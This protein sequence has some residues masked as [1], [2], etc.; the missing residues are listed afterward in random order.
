MLYSGAAFFITTLKA[1]SNIYVTC[2]PKISGILAKEIQ[3][4]GYQ[5]SSTL[6]KGVL[7]K[8]DL[9][10]CMN[11]NLHLRTAN[12]VLLEIEHFR[13]ENADQFYDAARKIRWERFISD[14]SYIS[15]DSF[16]RNDSIQDNRFANLRLKDAVVDR[17]Q[18]IL[19]ARPNSG[20]D[21]TGTCIYI[22]WVQDDCTLYFDTSGE[23]IAK[24]GYRKNPGKAP[25]Q[26]TLAAALLLESRW[27][28]ALPLVNPMCGSGTLAIEA[29]LIATRTA[30]GLFRENFGF[31]HLLTFEPTKWQKLVDEAIRQKE[32]YSGRIY[33]SDID[34]NAVRISQENA[35]SAGM[36]EF[37][38]FETCDFRSIQLPTEPGVVIMNPEYG[39]RLGEEQ[40]LLQIYK[41]IGDFFKK[42]CQGYW[43]YVFTGNMNLAKSIGLKTKRRVEFFNGR[44]DCRLLEYELYSGSKKP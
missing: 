23:T 15:I 38:D 26:E 33:A 44:I 7:L 28:P 14:E 9:E 19:G 35:S 1:Q 25:L 30:P 42:R 13:A 18:E 32:P 24:H 40:K 11:L 17:L 3:E 5:V 22:H 16:V 27:N 4:L 39:E 43:G 29:A 2:A 20:P 10:V 36:A 31:M 34:R 6:P 21:K 12:K 41:E 37:I 8:G